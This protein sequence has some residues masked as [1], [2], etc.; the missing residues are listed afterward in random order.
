MATWET[1]EHAYHEG[2]L[3]LLFDD[4][5]GDE[6]QLPTTI[7][8]KITLRKASGKEVVLHKLTENIY[9]QVF[10]RT[11]NEPSFADFRQKHL[12][13]DNV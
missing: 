4:I 9:N 10:R 7:P 11:P 6:S 2:F 8:N 3:Q 1:G 13:T 12:G 5:V